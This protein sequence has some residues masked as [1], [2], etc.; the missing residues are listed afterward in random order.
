[1]RADDL[2]V[3]GESNRSGCFEGFRFVAVLAIEPFR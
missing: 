2:A 1:L 3:R